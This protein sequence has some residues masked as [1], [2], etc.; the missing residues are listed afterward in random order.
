MT[1]DL[2]AE[3]RRLAE[4]RGHLARTVLALQ[5]EIFLFRQQHR[6]LVAEMRLEQGGDHP[7]YFRAK[8]RGWA[9]RLSA[10]LP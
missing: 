1:D 7:S 9:D 6:T 5:Q 2:R 8:I 4:E 3:C 10:G